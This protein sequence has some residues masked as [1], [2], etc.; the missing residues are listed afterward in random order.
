MFEEKIEKI[1]KEN[2]EMFLL[3]SKTIIPAIN[4]TAIEI[5][6]AYKNGGKL[7][8]F[9]NGGSAADAQHIAAELVGR[10]LKEREPLEAIALNTNVSNL[11]AIANDYGYDE[12]FI[13][14][15]KCHLKENDIVF[16]ISTSGNSKN[17]NEAIKYAKTKGNLTIGLTGKDGGELGKLVD[18]HI[19]I[20]K[21]LSPRIQEAHITIGHILCEI[22]EEQL[23]T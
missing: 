19:N 14:Q 4:K 6:K 5:V 23:F 22:I 12:V 8:I 7:I 2:S 1:L 3:L 10:F 9:G 11:T 20:N 15:L 13:R 18:I 21:N 16:G 17:V